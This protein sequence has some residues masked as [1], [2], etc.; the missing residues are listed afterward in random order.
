MPAKPDLRRCSDEGNTRRMASTR[1]IPSLLVVSV[2]ATMLAAGCSK[3]DRA[4][5]TTPGA[6]TQADANEPAA[7]AHE[8]EG[9]HE[10]DFSGSVVAFHDTMA[11]LWH[12]DAGDARVADTCAAMDDLIGKAQ[13]IRSDAAPDNV[14]DPEAWTAAASELVRVAEALQTT[15][16][17]SP[18]DFDKSF[19]A[20]HEAFHALVKLEGHEAK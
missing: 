1:S 20:L 15:C 2:A 11:P 9:K 16:A 12:A 14:A 8:H 13:T 7:A 6:A 17:D 18:P 10:H 4:P 3:A 5:T 19:E